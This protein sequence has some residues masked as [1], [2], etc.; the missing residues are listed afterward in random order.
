MIFRPKILA[1]PISIALAMRAS[2]RPTIQEG[3][4][5]YGFKEKPVNEIRATAFRNVPE[6]NLFALNSKVIEFKPPSKVNSEFELDDSEEESET[7]TYVESKN[8]DSRCLSYSDIG[9]SETSGKD[10]KFINVPIS[11]T[12]NPMYIDPSESELTGRIIC[13][14]DENTYESQ[15]LSE[16]EC[17]KR[18]QKETMTRR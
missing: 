12:P 4:L 9:Y 7:D 17:I 15:L 14:E 3:Q 8:M 10:R 16:L 2:Q 13:I 11:T 5:S 1:D 18:M 6:E